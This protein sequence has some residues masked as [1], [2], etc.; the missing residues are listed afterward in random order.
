MLAMVLGP[1]V[2]GAISS[3]TTWR[4]IFLFNVPVG[5]VALALAVLGI[6]RG[7]PHHGR[8]AKKTTL[9]QSLARVDFLGCSLLFLATLT[10]TA[11]FQEAGSRFAWDSAYFIT[12]LV[13]SVLLWVAL[14]VW[15]R[16]VT[17]A[18]GVMEPV[19]P[20]RFLNNRAMAG[21]LL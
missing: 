3:N 14:L 21:I 17:L 15:E 20:W 11:A 5:A 7:F 8:P 16:R 6:P 9:R 18:D 4:W 19:L 10:F 1:I 2:G 13:V 12:L